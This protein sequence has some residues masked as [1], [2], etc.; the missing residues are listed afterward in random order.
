M[1]VI[2]HRYFFLLAILLAILA[3]FYFVLTVPLLENDSVVKLVYAKVF[4]E[5]AIIPKEHTLAT[6]LIGLG[7]MLFGE[8][9]LVGRFIELAAAVGSIYLTYLM[10]ARFY[11]RRAGLYGAF[12]LSLVPVHLFYSTISKVYSLLCFLSLL[13]LYLFIIGFKEKKPIYCLASALVLYLSFLCKTFTLIGVVPFVVLFLMSF[14]K[15]GADRQLFHFNFKLT[16]AS[17]LLLS[18]LVLATFYWRLPEFGRFFYHDSPV[19]LSL[20]LMMQYLPSSWSSL[21]AFNSI[22]SFTLFP[23]LMAAALTRQKDVHLTYVNASIFS[24]IAVNILVVVMNPLNHSPRGFIISMPLLCLLAGAALSKLLNST[25]VSKR[26]LSQII[27]ASITATTFSFLF[28]FR[29]DFNPLMVLEMESLRDIIVSFVS[30]ILCHFFFQCLFLFFLKPSHASFVQNKKNLP[31]IIVSPLLI[32]HFLFGI[33]LT[34]RSL[35]NQANYFNPLFDVV[36][37]APSCNMIGGEDFVS[38]FDGTSFAF[39]SDLPVDDLLKVASGDLDSILEKH[40]INTIVL[41]K[42]TSFGEEEILRGF[43]ETK[44]LSP[45]RHRQ[46]L[47]SNKKIDRIFDNGAAAIYYYTPLPSELCNKSET[48]KNYMVPLQMTIGSTRLFFRDSAGSKNRLSFTI[49]NTHLT[50]RRYFVQVA[51]TVS[52]KK[53]EFIISETS[54]HFYLQEVSVNLLSKENINIDL[55]TDSAIRVAVHV[56]DLTDELDYFIYRQL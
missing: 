26:N 30:I 6:I 46:A 27:A 33:L 4:S 43:A 2:T 44:G 14:A 8:N 41:R 10:G 5:N 15:K 13:S 28:S 7:F 23:L 18:F 56:I 38:L 34:D 19:D 37:F 53:G 16:G 47:N 11:D 17:I 39:F 12:F 55:K 36:S 29:F 31:F 52:D 49:E 42:K 1:K 48:L 22:S 54:H 9:I 50:P 24:L 3:R 20:Q 35:K 45:L 51:E 32:S 25:T 21:L 40:T